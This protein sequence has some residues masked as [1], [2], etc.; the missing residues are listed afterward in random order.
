MPARALYANY[1]ALRAAAHH[2]RAWRERLWRE[3]CFFRAVLGRFLPRLVLIAIIL[4]VGAFLFAALQPAKHTSIVRAVYYTWSLIFGQPPD[5]FP[6]EAPLQILYFVLPLLGLTVIVEAVVDF[7]MMLRDRR[8]HEHTW[9]KTMA[10]ALSNHVVLV[11][12]GKLGIRT[13]TLLRALGQQVVVIE[14]NEQNQFLDDVRRDGAPL[15]IGDARREALLGDANVAEARSIILAANDDLANL[16]VAL[17]ARKINPRI[18]V[19]LRMFDQNMADKVRDGFNIH[20]AM[21]QSALAAP[22]FAAAALD[23]A[24]LSSML[25]GDQLVVLRRWTMTPNS[26]FV[27]RTV[28]EVLESGVAVVEH[29]TGTAQSRLFPPPSTHLSAGD[30]LLVQGPLP[31]L[32]K[33]DNRPG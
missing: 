31:T 30:E 29:R 1:A 27:G 17:D 7:A 23:R 2:R 19:V 25:I 24:N 9:C 33:L 4:S 22:A 26:P 6:D 32:E 16:E 13:Y 28:G 20:I 15:L 14:R 11:G 3:W 12:L 18:R 8:R 21:S 5:A 10:H